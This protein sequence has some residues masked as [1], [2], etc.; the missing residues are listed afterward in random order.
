MVLDTNQ[1][2]IQQILLCDDC[3]YH[4]QQ[5]KDDIYTSSNCQF[6][7]NDFS[8]TSDSFQIAGEQC[9]LIT[10]E[11]ECPVSHDKFRPMHQSFWLVSKTRSV[12]FKIPRTKVKTKRRQQNEE[13]KNNLL[14]FT[15]NLTYI[16]DVSLVIFKDI[17]ESLR[18]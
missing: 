4:P 2:N 9:K 8:L 16:Y 18:W 7:F 5:G 15:S 14:D 13:K 3:Y 17:V 12:P 1:A 6:G 10:E 11:Q